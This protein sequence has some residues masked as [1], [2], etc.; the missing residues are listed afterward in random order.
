MKSSEITPE[1]HDLERAQKGRAGFI[2]WRMGDIPA[3]YHALVPVSYNA[4]EL[5]NAEQAV[6]SQYEHDV[7]FAASPWRR[8]GPPCCLLDYTGMT[9]REE[10]EIAL[11]MQVPLGLPDAPKRGRWSDVPEAMKVMARD[12]VD[13]DRK[14]R[15][16]EEADRQAEQHE[17]LKAAGQE[18]AWTPQ[19]AEQL[20]AQHEA[21]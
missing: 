11:Q 9:G 1:Q 8:V 7:A 10:L 13:A 16:A 18:P 19:T 21:E 15:Y 12:A 6:R 5:L 17:L 4:A 14:R 3:I 2:A 20:E